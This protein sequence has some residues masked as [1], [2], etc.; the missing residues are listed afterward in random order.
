MLAAED[1]HILEYDHEHPER[2]GPTSLWNLHRLCWLHHQQKTAGRTDPVRDPED[3]EDHARY[4]AGRRPIGTTWDIDREIRARTREE[5]DLLTP[6]LAELLAT[7]WEHYR[8]AHADAARLREEQEQTPPAQRSA[9]E[10]HVIRRRAEGRPAAPP[11]K[12]SDGRSDPPP[13]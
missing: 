5:R 2:G 7:S 4:A 9:E 10:R 13:F 1:D 8:R 6:I 11:P 3:P 12:P